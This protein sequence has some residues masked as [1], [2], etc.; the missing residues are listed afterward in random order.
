MKRLQAIPAVIPF[1]SLLYSPAF[2]FRNFYFLVLCSI[3]LCF[4]GQ[5]PAYASPPVKPDISTN[6]TSLKTTTIFPPW[7]HGAN[8]DA[9]ARGLDFTVPDADNLADFHG[10]PCK[11]SLV[12]YVGGNYFFAMAPLIT[13]FEKKY[14]EYQNHIYWETLPPGLLIK[15]IQNG[16]TVT[17]GNMTWTVQAD[18]YLAGLNAVSKQIKAGILNAPAVPY[19]TNRLT[20]MVPTDNP[21]KITGLNDLWRPDLRLAMPDPAFEGIAKQIKVALFHAGG[22]KLVQ[23]VYEIK[24]A[25]G[26]TILTHIHHRQTPLWLMQGKVQA[27]VTW[28][29]EAIFQQ[30]IGHPLTL[31]AIP[32]HENI[33]AIY[34]G[35]LVK[36][37]P[38]PAAAQRWMDFIR[39]PE[40]LAIF[41]AYGFKPYSTKEK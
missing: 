20:L 22:K 1:S 41:A 18:V 21:A 3:V 33:T 31:I 27:G 5:I 14:P 24:V 26:T 8:N 34:A 13:A 36:G 28:Q 15:Q 7:Q 9:A 23:Q 16:G 6:H 39:S 32:D 11:P 38:H 25:Q 2:Y 4:L 30:K 35:A 19:V 17:V 37:T 29:S 10:N 12:L 40:G